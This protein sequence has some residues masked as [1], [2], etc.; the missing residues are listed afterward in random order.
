MLHLH[1][2]YE[3]KKYYIVI[4]PVVA[5]ASHGLY[6]ASFILNINVTKNQNNY[7]CIIIHNTILLSEQISLYQTSNKDLNIRISISYHINN[8]ISE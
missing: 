3:E 5:R 2:H 4:Q 7:P 6:L 8:L 1:Q